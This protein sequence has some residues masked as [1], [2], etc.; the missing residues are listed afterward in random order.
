MTEHNP[1]LAHLPLPDGWERRPSTMNGEALCLLMATDAKE[2]LAMPLD[3][4]GPREIRV[5]LFRPRMRHAALQF[6]LSTDRFWRQVR[7]ATFIEDPGGAVQDVSLGVFDLQPDCRLL[8]RTVLRKHAAIAYVRLCPAPPPSSPTQRA[9][10]GAVFDVYMVMNQHRIDE[11]DDLR[12]VIAP[13]ADS[14]FD[15]ICWGSAAGSFRALH[16]SEVIE[17]FGQGQEEFGNVNGE[18]TGRVMSMFAHKGLDP[19][20]LIVDFAHEIGLQLWSDDRICHCYEPGAYRDQFANR[21]LLENQHMRVLQR[22]GAPEFQATLSLAYPEFRDLKVR[23]LTEQASAGA[24]GIYIDFMRKYPVVGWEPPVLDSFKEK[25]GRDPRGLPAEEW[26]EPWLAHQCGFVTRFMRDLRASLNE[27]GEQSGRRIPVAV[28]THGGWRFTHDIPECYLYGLDVATWAREGLIDIFAPSPSDNLWHELMSL[29]RTRP[30]V[31]DT[32]C[33]IWPC[34][35]QFAPELYPNG[36]NPNLHC[37]EDP[38]ADVMLRADLDPWRIARAADDL[39]NQ[40]ADGLFV[41]EMHEAAAVP[42]HWEVLRRLGDR[43]WLRRT[44]GRPI[45]PFDGSHVIEQWPLQP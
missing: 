12:A 16:F 22:D 13:F 5:G 10:L 14:C 39:Y 4:T 2:P 36:R 20:R 31:A 38:E 33:E 1:D 37:V 8:V 15:R 11:P 28:Q 27:V 34:L 44:F 23:F 9:K 24:D 42:Q 7:P 29:D 18:H 45:G 26:F 40:A 41:W 19:L 17:H 43:E 35:G 30:L 21:F 3:A 25:F 32:N 6:R